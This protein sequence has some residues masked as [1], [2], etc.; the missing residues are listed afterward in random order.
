VVDDQLG[1][2]T[3]APDIAEAILA[4]A[5]KIIASGWHD[6]FA[7]ITHLAGPDEITWCNFARQIICIS[8][9]KGGRD[10]SVDAIMSVEYPTPAERPA[11]SRMCCDRL[12]HLFDVRL[13]PLRSS[14]ENCLERLLN[15]RQQEDKA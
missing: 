14:L 10:V 3:Y 11:N 5:F 7:G 12:A 4:I 13:P 15:G 1:C 2:P 9:T 6:H 8:K